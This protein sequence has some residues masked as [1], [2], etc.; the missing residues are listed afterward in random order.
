M[1]N[2]TFREIAAALEPARTVLVASHLRPDGDALGSTIAFALWLKSL[3]KEVT[4]WNEDGMLDKFRYLPE[5]DLVSKPE[6]AGR[7]FDAFVALDTSVKNR[8]GTVLDAIEE[9][10]LFVNIDHHISNG[11]YGAVNYIDSSSPATG[12]I[13][14]EFLKEIGAE[15]TP[16]IAANLFAAISTD[17]GSFQY[18]STT[19]TTYRVGAE[20]IEAGVNVGALSQA[21][22]DSQPRRRLELL[23]HALNDAKFSEDGR[24]V[25]FSLTQDDVARLG[26][27]PEDNEGI[28]DHL[29][30]VDSV[31]AA[32]FFEELEGGKVRVSSRSK[33]P[34]VDV[35]KV[36]GVFGGGG[37]ALASGARMAGPLKDAEEK[38]LKVLCDEVGR[39]D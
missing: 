22:Y 3:G 17:T 39:I 12:Q 31:V 35:C 27:L 4:A 15:I 13:V 18:P 20:L 38:F 29:R 23:R 34:R 10:A 2:P 33:D 21:M 36:C 14:F 1:K 16:A 30:S 7:K 32:V 11:R 19:A 28:I 25:S 24:V 8:L 9:P 26:V 5:A 37:H 6:G